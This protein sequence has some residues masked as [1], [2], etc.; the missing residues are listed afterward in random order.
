VDLERFDTH[1]D[2]LEFPS[3]RI[4]LVTRLIAGQ[5]ATVLQLPV[6]TKTELPSEA[7]R[8]GRSDSDRA[9][10]VPVARIA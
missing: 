6:R 8:D 7:S 3:G 10:A 9:P 4:V 1:H 5:R 2:A